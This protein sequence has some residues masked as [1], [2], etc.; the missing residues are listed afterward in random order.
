[1]D[2]A[3]DFEKDAVAGHRVGWARAAQDRRVHRAERRDDH[4][5]GDPDGSTAADDV[6]DHV[7]GD[8]PRSGYAGKGQDLQAGGAEQQINDGYE[9]D[10]PDQRAR[11]IFLRLCH[12]GT[13]QIQILPA[14]VSPQ[15]GSQR[16]EERAKNCGGA[17]SC[18]RPERLDAA[19][20]CRGRSE[21]RYADHDRYGRDFYSR[22]KYLH[23]A[24]QL[25]A[26]IVDGGHYGYP[27]DR[28]RLCPGEHEIVRRDPRGEAGDGD[29]HGEEWRGDAGHQKTE[30]AHHPRADRSQRTGPPDDRVH[31]P[32]E[33]SVDWTESAA[34][35]SVFAAS[36]RN[37]RA[38][39][40]ERKRAEDGKNRADD[41]RR[42][43][44]GDGF[45]FAGHFRGLEEDAGAD[46]SAYDD[47]SGSP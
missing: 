6:F 3:D 14:V 44:Y 26:E 23:R 25:Y 15:S 21:E 39:F 1:M 37:H 12:F 22:E 11:E 16:S 10:A 36:F 24:A 17:S 27:E 20:F 42:E 34:Q 45:A 30:K 41:P 38:E 29:V 8:V 35:V 5:D 18:G 47:G 32:E 7:R 43:N 4:G 40:G 46:H 9:S 19:A 28:E 2:A 33:K 31:P 13:D